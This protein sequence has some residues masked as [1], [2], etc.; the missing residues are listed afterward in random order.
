MG[1]HCMTAIAD[2]S[3]GRCQERDPVDGHWL[4]GSG[5]RGRCTALGPLFGGELRDLLAFGH[6][7]SIHVATGIGPRMAVFVVARWPSND[8]FDL[9]K[10]RDQRHALGLVYRPNQNGRR[11]SCLS[12]DRWRQ[13]LLGQWLATSSRTALLARGRAEGFWPLP[14]ARDSRL[15]GNRHGAKCLV[16][17]GLAQR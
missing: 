11:S 8:T 7:A 3:C 14:R 17:H 1:S 4:L 10:L 15:L 16:H 9:Q 13:T 12:A 5:A 6:T 2:R